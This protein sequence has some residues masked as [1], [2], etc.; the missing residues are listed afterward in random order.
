MAFRRALPNELG[1]GGRFTQN[2]F[3]TIRGQY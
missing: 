1:I 2:L 3:Q